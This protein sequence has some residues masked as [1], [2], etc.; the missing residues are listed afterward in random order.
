MNSL[1]KSGITALFFLLVAVPASIAQLQLLPG[2]L[3]I[4]ALG[5]ALMQ[6]NNINKTVGY[7]I[8]FVTK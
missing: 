5:D 6:F 1:F 4:D 3:K 7:D 2:E 8:L